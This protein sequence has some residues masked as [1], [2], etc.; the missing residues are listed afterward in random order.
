MVVCVECVRQWCG[1]VCMVGRWSFKVW[2][3]NRVCALVR[4]W[5]F[6]VACVESV[7]QWCGVVCVVGRWSF[8]I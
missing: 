8:G 2:C 3:V 5:E 6:M 4:W 7:R 1:V